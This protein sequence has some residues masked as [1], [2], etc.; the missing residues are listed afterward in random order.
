MGIDFERKNKTDLYRVATCD[1]N[2]NST[3]FRIVVDDDGTISVE[4][5][6]CGESTELSKVV[7]EAN[8]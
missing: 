2:C 6:I 4:C 8:K 3:A 7:E 5:D 1:E